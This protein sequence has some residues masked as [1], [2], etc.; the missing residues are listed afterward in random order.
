[1]TDALNGAANGATTTTPQQ[2]LAML[3]RKR[4]AGMRV[5]PISDWSFARDINAVPLT[6]VE[7]SEAARELPIGFVH[8]GTDEQGKPRIVA[9]ALLG[10][11]ERENLM[12]GSDGRW[13]GH[14]VPATM[15]RYP[16]AFVRTQGSDQLSLVIDE[17]YGGLGATDGELMLS[18]DGEPTDFLQQIMRFLERYEAELQ[19][20]ELFCARL[21]ALDLLRGAEIKGELPGGGPISAAGF[22]MVDEEKLNKL[23]DAELLALQ[24]SGMLALIYAHMIS[25]GQVQALAQR[26]DARAARAAA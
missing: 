3:D 1:M 8:A 16:F 26:I 2:R 9:M 24:R 19:R 6:G 20:T 11:R 13:D 15:R 18:A 22:Y 25:M 17:N 4:H 7:F 23:P 10:L 5:R 14:F 12:V 21:V